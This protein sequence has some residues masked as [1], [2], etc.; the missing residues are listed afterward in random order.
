VSARLQSIEPVEGSSRQKLTYKLADGKVVEQETGRTM[1]AMGM[2]SVTATLLQGV[3][4]GFDPKTDRA[5]VTGQDS[6]YGDASPLGAQLKT[7]DKEHD[8]FFAG[9]TSGLERT[10]GVSY[11]QYFGWK[12]LLLTDQ[13]LAPRA[14]DGPS[15][16]SELR[17]DR[18][19]T[20]LTGSSATAG[21]GLG[22]SSTRAR[23]GEDP[24]LAV[25]AGLSNVLADFV[26]KGTDSLQLTFKQEDGK[27][28]MHAPLDATSINA[29]RDTLDRQSTL[30]GLIGNLA[31]S[32]PF[33]VTARLNDGQVIGLE[34]SVPAP[35]K[36]LDLPKAPPPKP[37]PKP[38]DEQ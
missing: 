23:T 14:G 11:L 27:L 33:V 36:D 12:N 24:T 2:K 35:A 29:L 13:V 18:K 31:K 16:F 22:T 3:A 9:L 19:P 20:S 17:E 10:E 8:I 7:G 6:V 37:T 15:P 30:A 5:P 38:A 25:K 21:A 28:V 4:P 1:L 34:T 32:G 26:L